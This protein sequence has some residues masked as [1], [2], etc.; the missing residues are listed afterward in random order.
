MFPAIH[1]L[2]FH[3]ASY[4]LL[5]MLGAAAF[6]ATLIGFTKS[7]KIDK[8]SFHRMLF[9]LILACGVTWV[10]A[11]LF[12]GLFHSIEERKLR[13]GGITW[14]GGIVGAFAFLIFA[15]HKFVPRAKGS[16]VEFLSYCV[17]GICIGH[18]LGRIGC[19]LGGCCYGR[20]T[21]SVFGVSFPAGSHAAAQYPGENGASL[22]VLPTQLFEAGFE[23][24]LFLVL[25]LTRKKTKKI[26][27]QIYMIAYG[28]FRFG[29]EFLRGDDRGSTGFF[30]SPAQVLSVLFVIAGILLILEEKDLLFHSLYQK[31][32][33]WKEKAE[34]HTEALLRAREKTS[35]LDLLKELYVLKEEGAISEEEY[36]DKKRDILNKF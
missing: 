29:L 14:L 10:S 1:I 25:I 6:F 35:E 30:L 32:R 16:A 31:R 7:E 15:F 33:V 27:A 8:I 3:I 24:F 12:D 13:F 21:D 22:P 2:G 34:A 23:F 26:G 28:A 17:P 9:L 5:M 4:G 11:F 36:E 19:F 18:A 20:V